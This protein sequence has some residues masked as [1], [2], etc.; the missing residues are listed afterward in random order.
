MALRFRTALLY[1]PLSL[2]VVAAGCG[3]SV[4]TSTNVTAPDAPRCQVSVTPSATTYRS[5]GGTGTLNIT[6][7]R[8]CSWSA[9][10]AAPW[11]AFTSAREGQGDGSV[12]YR[13]DA[14]GDPITRRGAVSVGAARVELSQEAA[15]C[16]Y[17]V[18]PASEPAPAIGGERQIIVRTHALCNWTAISTAPWIAPIP[19]S[20]RGEGVVRIVF[21]ENPGAARAA[22]VVVANQRVTMSQLARV[23]PPPTAP[24]PP[25]PAPPSP[26]PP[27]PAPP[28]PAP[29]PGA[30]IELDGRVSSLSGSCPTVTF[31]TDGRTVWTHSNTRFRGGSCRDLRNRTEV[32]IEGRLMSDG[33]VRADNI[34]LEDDD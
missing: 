23:A 33:T 1:L 21:T 20:G 2:A 5:A 18:T 8:E 30:P 15:P 17:Q 3:S 24:T 9:S 6:V 25:S 26:A 4:T 7:A 34:R 31:Q 29:T 22:D 19:A 16:R 32:E 12:A 13:V 11:I 10:S 28:A 27:A 14:N